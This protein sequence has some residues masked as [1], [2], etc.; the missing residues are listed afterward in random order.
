MLIRSFGRLIL[1]NDILDD[2]PSDNENSVATVAYSNVRLKSEKVLSMW[3][4]ILSVLV[5][6]ILLLLC[7]IGFWMIGFFERKKFGDEKY[8]DENDKLKKTPY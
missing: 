1:S 6:L 2:K 3:V 7:T 8:L 4:Y 5:G